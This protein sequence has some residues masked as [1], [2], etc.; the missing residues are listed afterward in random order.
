MRQKLG[1]RWE[2]ARKSSWSQRR[3]MPPFAWSSFSSLDTFGACLPHTTSTAQRG[4]CR[5]AAG[6]P[7]WACVHECSCWRACMRRALAACLY[8]GLRQCVSSRSGLHAC[9]RRY[10]R[11]KGVHRRPKRLPRGLLSWII[12]VYRIKQE[13]VI[14]V[15]G[16]DA[17]TYMRILTM[18][19]RTRVARWSTAVLPKGSCSAR[20]NACFARAGTELFVFVAFWVC[21]VVLPTNLTVCALLRVKCEGTVHLLWRPPSCKMLRAQYTCFGCNSAEQDLAG[22]LW[23]R[24]TRWR[25]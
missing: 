15:A 8:A 16:Y 10:K 18:G 13:E 3:P 2:Q 4:V 5:S 23:R 9:T 24:A 22:W 11:G 19:E 6:A 1:T 21:V 17:A 20:L 12:A 25:R 7:H 14:E